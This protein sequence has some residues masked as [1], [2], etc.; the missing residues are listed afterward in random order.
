MHDILKEPPLDRPQNQEEFERFMES[1]DRRFVQH[2]IGIPARQLAAIPEIMRAFE[3][4]NFTVPRGEPIAGS[5]APRD[6]ALRAFAWF[7]E[8][9]GDAQKAYMGSGHGLV[10][11]RGQVWL[12]RYP[13][14]FGRCAFHTGGRPDS[15]YLI[16]SPS[17]YD[18]VSPDSP[19]WQDPDLPKYDVFDYLPDLPERMRSTL[20]RHEVH[21]LAYVFCKYRL[22][23]DA[24]I[25]ARTRKYVEAAR[26]DLDA[27]ARMLAP[28]T[29]TPGIAR[30]SCLQAVEKLFKSYL[31]HR[32]EKYPTGGPKAHDLAA[33]SELVAA[34]GGP[35]FPSELLDQVQCAAGVRYEPESV[36]SHDAARAH[37]AALELAGITALVLEGL[38]S[39]AGDL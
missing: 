33:L 14:I 37:F 34:A 1:M 27:A 23:L 25:R 11:L 15:L 6:V 5:F 31:H 17:G 12:I 3:L 38:L 18:S 7:D 26:G 20:P 13:A 10:I 19:E 39:E 8:K 29:N 21:G 4:E 35:R 28:S 22:Y 30:W 32:G 36:S 9:Y 16:R 2:G 24:L